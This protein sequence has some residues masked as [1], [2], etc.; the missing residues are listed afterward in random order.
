MLSFAKFFL[1][2]WKFGDLCEL[3]SELKMSELLQK[4]WATFTHVRELKI[5]GKCEP[6]MSH[7]REW[8]EKKITHVHVC[9]SLFVISFETSPA[10][11]LIFSEAFSPIIDSNIF[12]STFDNNDEIRNNH[13]KTR[14]LS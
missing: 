13:W 14:L 3:K 8:T 2:K 10:A 12:E 11:D 5:W 9:P 4:K 1:K 7:V 6:I